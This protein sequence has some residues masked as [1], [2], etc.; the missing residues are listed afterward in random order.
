MLPKGKMG[1]QYFS[2]RKLS[3]LESGT[4]GH[5]PAQPRAARAG[6]C[7]R[8]PAGGHSWCPRLGRQSGLSADGW[9]HRDPALKLRPP[10]RRSSP[11][12]PSLPMPRTHPM[13]QAP[14]PLRELLGPGEGRRALSKARAPAGGGARPCLQRG[15]CV[16]PWGLRQTR[17]TGAPPV[18]RRR[19]PVGIARVFG[20]PA[21]G[22]LG[23]LRQ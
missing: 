20:E 4:S 15:K 3:R 5:Q 9:A 21:L 12:K 18:S 22:P 7:S 11:V 8:R 10:R 23:R 13:S 19:L 14:L 16:C 6:P 1:L 17:L 2:T